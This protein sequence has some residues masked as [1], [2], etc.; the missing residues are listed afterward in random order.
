[1]K[2]QRPLHF[3]LFFVAH[4]FLR[5]IALGFILGQTLQ[6]FPREVPLPL[7]VAGHDEVFLWMLREPSFA[8]IQQLLDLVLAN[9]IV[10]LIVEYGN[11]HIRWA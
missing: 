1:M 9:P 5:L 3:L 10:L 11:K 7:Q 2:T 4:S 6:R 8:T